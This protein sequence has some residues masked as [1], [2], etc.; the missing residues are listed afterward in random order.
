MVGH[1]PAGMYIPT[2]WGKQSR[3]GKFKDTKGKRNAQP[4]KKEACKRRK[5][6][7]ETESV[8]LDNTETCEEPVGDV[9]PYDNIIH[10]IS[11]VSHT[12]NTKA[13]PDL[14][15]I[16]SRVPYQ[17]ML[18][19]LFGGDSRVP[20][21]V[22]IITRVY[23]ESFMRECEN[24]RERQCVMGDSCECMFIDPQHPFVCIEFLL[25]DEDVS[26]THRNMCVICYRKVTQQLFHD[27]LFKGVSFRGTIQRFGNICDQPGEYAREAMLICPP[28]SSVH[29][30]ILP[31]VAHQ[32]NRYSVT[33]QHGV[34]YLRQ[35]RVYYEDFQMPPV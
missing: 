9:S 17:Q 14:D 27:M 1:S 16:L 20:P 12:G 23:E 28:N 15:T 19:D 35:H 31:V 26:P 6:R 4:P 5:V 33:V 10:S 18:Q 25:P 30:M 24:S 21:D 22:P 13:V 3:D 8:Q 34:R 32:R 29:N 7:C 2:D 11:R